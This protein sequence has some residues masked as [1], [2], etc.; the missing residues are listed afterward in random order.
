ME[1]AAGIAVVGISG[2]EEFD[3]DLGHLEAQVVLLGGLVE[4]A[5]LTSLLTLKARDCE[6][7]KKVIEDDDLIDDKRFEIEDASIA[8]A[9]REAPVARDLRRIITILL[10]AGELERIGDYAEGIAKITLLLADQPPL[11]GLAEIPRMGDR[12]ISMLKHSLEAF[13]DRDPARAEARALSV[14]PDDDAVDRMYLQMRSDLLELMKQSPDN[15]EAGTYLMWAGHNV[16]RIADRATNI[17]ERVVFQA[18]GRIVSV[19]G[20]QDEAQSPR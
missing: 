5:V 2:R 3:R 7:A 15:I 1:Q 4:S 18:T 16:E 17:A 11:K 14:G 6:L 12:A 10:I 9:R 19:G 13:L 20:D 8:L